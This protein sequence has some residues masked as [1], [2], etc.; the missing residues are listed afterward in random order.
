MSVTR[1]GRVFQGAPRLPGLEGHNVYGR[2]LN[3]PDTFYIYAYLDADRNLLYVG[4]TRAM[5]GR[6][7][8]HHRSSAWYPLASE[9]RILWTTSDRR[10]ALLAEAKAIRELSPAFNIYHNR[11]AA[12]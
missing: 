3:L 12:A 8:A 11:G 7:A 10:E 6:N 2:R 1:R 5:Q 9:V 4:K